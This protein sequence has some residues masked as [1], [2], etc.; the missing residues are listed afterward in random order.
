MP[1]IVSELDRYEYLFNLAV[2][3]GVA[4]REPDAAWMVRYEQT[5]EY[6]ACAAGRYA[7]LRTVYERR[8]LAA[9]GGGDA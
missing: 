1:A 8:R 5:E 6:A 2:R 7:R 3:D 4:L 9:N